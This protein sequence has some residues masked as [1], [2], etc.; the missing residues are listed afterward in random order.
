MTTEINERH[1]T[2]AD[3]LETYY[4]EPG[5]SMPVMMHL[6]RCGECAARYDRLARK[7]RGIGACESERPASFWSRQRSS[8]LQQVGT[9]QHGRRW[10][11]TVARLAAAAVFVLTVGGIATWREM[12]P[13][14]ASHPQAAAAAQPVEIAADDAQVAA[15]PWQSEQLR[16]FQD[17]VEWES[18]VEPPTK[19]EQSL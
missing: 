6:A 17:V 14:A 9:R 4:T 13:A 7:L 8:I 15:D 12:T 3:L 2:E 16:E 10:G 5:A 11:G 19:G 18:W 1:Y